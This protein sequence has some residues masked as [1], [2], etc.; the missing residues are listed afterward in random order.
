MTDCNPKELGT[1]NFT[2]LISEKLQQRKRKAA[3]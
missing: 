2:E 1:A 3:I